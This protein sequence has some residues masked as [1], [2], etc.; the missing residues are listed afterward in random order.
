MMLCDM[1]RFFCAPEGAPTDETAGDVVDKT[2]RQ[3]PPGY[4]ALRRGRWSEFGRAYMV[5]TVT[6]KRAP[7]FADLMTGRA[8][9]RQM[10]RLESDGLVESL[11]FVLM[12]DHLHWLL[13]LGENEDL[14]RLVGLF[15]GRSAREVN[16]A[17]NRKGP[18]W[19]RAFYDHALRKDEDVRKLAR[20]IV[21]NPV[22]AGIVK[23]AADYP[24]WDAVWVDPLCA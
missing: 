24:L 12:P 5:T 7:V 23:R 2:D 16:K 15:K 22:R 6:E 9:V 19:Q 13:V 1:R 17:L 4:N 8:V 11:A 3:F 14:S 18:L 10:M 20:Y 21:A